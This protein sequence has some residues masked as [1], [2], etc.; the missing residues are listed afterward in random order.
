M[1]SREME[2]GGRSHGLAVTNCGK[3]VALALFGR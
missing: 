3:R 2:V 1:G